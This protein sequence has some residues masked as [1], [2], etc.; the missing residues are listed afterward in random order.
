METCETCQKTFQTKAAIA[1]H[2]GMHR[3][4]REAMERQLSSIAKGTTDCFYGCGNKARF[5]LK[6]LRACC[7]QSTNQCPALRKINSEKL[8]GRRCWKV[9]P[10]G[11]IGKVAWN[12][13]KH[14]SEEHR[15]KISVSNK[16]H[17]GRAAT[18][19]KELL[20]RESLRVSIK[21]RYAKGWMP[22]AGRC[23]K[24]SHL[25][26]ICGSVLL[27]GSWELEFAKFLD[28]SGMTWER[29]KKRFPY[30]FEGEDRHYTPDF[31]FAGFNVFV[32]VK[33]YITPKDRA[34][35][36]HFPCK[37]RVVGRVEINRIKQGTIT[38]EEIIGGLPESGNGS[39]C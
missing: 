10:R 23:K 25:S 21:E 36:A 20:R 1:N 11:M 22:K 12:R 26:P 16:G 37:L 28:K 32:E 33:G 38:I 2:L 13:G 31:Y 4:Q 24:I 7:H 6:N 14:L 27:D 30:S 17:G 3:R 8:K 39:A 18:E 19:E 5:V 29:N 9:H 34:K 35:W 15:K